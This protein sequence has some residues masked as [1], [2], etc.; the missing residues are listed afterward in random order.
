MAKLSKTGSPKRA[1]DPDACLDEPL[2]GA[3]TIGECRF[4]QL[5]EDA[6]GY[7]VRKGWLDAD[8][9]GRLWRSTPRRLRDQAAGRGARRPDPDNRERATV[10]G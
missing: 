1:S 8:R 7:L 2:W 9:V 6:A 3:K 4:V 10:G 5:N